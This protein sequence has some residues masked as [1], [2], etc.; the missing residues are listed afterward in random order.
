[1]PEKS[2]YEGHRARLRE[3]FSRGGFECLADYEVVELLL[4]LCIPR[5]DV[6]PMAKA[7]MKKFGS[8]RGVL[9]APAEALR[10]VPGLGAVAPVALR[11]IRETATLYLRQTVE[12]RRVLDNV[13][14]LEDFWRARLGTLRHEVFEVAY[15]DHHYQLLEDGVERV[16]EGTV[17]ETTVY[18]RKV[19]ESA[20]RRQAAR[21][22]VAH[23]HPTGNTAPSEQDKKL[24][25]ALQ[26]AG[27]PLGIKVI[28]HVIVA[29]E[30][31]FSFRKS[32]LIAPD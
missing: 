12:G 24:T 13:D 20:L 15:L 26:Q 21:I 11:V 14:K 31:T 32:K 16:E 8:V 18:P 7:L 27:Q 30:K 3:R 5:R 1:M 4:T 2:S 10:E 9:D 17:D 23:N 28:D 22:V 25:R 19:M 6:K 29:A